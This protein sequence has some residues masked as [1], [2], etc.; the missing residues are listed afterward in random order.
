VAYYMIIWQ[1]LSGWIEENHKVLSLDSL[2][3]S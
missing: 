2:C 3:R 1:N